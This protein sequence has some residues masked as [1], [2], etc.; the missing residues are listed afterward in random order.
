MH[1]IVERVCTKNLKVTLLFIDFSKAFNFIHRIKME[2]ILRAC[3]LS[4][5]T[6]TSIMM[7]YLFNSD[8]N[9]FDI[10]TGVCKEVH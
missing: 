10:V 2:Q 7:F 6:V 1:R 9:F 5:E 3:G 4:K 8:T